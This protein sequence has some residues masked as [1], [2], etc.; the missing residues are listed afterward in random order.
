MVAVG[1]PTTARQTTNPATSA[2][3]TQRGGSLLYGWAPASGRPAGRP[4]YGATG[5]RVPS[6]TKGKV[7]NLRKESGKVVAHQQ[8]ALPAVLEH[9][10]RSLRHEPRPRAADFNQT[11]ELSK[12]GTMCSAAPRPHVRPTTL[13]DSLRRSSGGYRPSPSGTPARGACLSN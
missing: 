7:C 6:H 9:W 11:R 13:P 12:V 8:H 4:H 5:W 1:I 2:E 10:A 3:Q